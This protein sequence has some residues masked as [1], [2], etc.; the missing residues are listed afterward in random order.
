MDISSEDDITKLKAM[1]YDQ[2]V[3]KEQAE[4]S[5]RLI[6]QRIDSLQKDDKDKNSKS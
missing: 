1:A 2:L 3:N 5:L 6:A 4:Y